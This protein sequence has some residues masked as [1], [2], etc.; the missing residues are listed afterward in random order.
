MT[1][2]PL[3]VVVLISGRG[4]NMATLIRAQ[5][6][7]RLNIRVS[8]VISSRQTAAGLKIA[9]QAG[10]PTAIT[11]AA[12]DASHAELDQALI[13]QISAFEP[14][15]VVLAGYMHILR[16]VVVNHFAGRMI[17]IHPS[18]LPA[19]KGL[20]THQ[21][22]LDSGDDTHGASTHFVTAELDC[23]AVI[24]QV[25]IPVLADDTADSLASRLLP[26]EH[27]LMT[28]TVELFSLG[29]VRLEHEQIYLDGAPLR[30]PLQLDRVHAP[31]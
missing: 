19:Y 26:F 22:V 16:P 6:S 18:I 2:K 17:N 15:L 8:G 24:A 11:Q 9:E 23:G 3:S 20:H 28:A 4:S 21:R 31:G 29:R 14:G 30:A 7:G 12:G 10:I 27:Q 5:Q 1:N 25:R 13:R